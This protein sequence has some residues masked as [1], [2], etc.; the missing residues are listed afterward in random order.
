[1]GASDFEHADFETTGR[2][3]AMSVCLIFSNGRGSVF[4]A[5]GKE[6]ESDKQKVQR[7]ARVTARVTGDLSA[8]GSG[9]VRLRPR[10]RGGAFRSETEGHRGR[11]CVFS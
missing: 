5:T 2:H 10:T 8:D 7:S 6:T 3:G 11:Q 1:M 4:K 9:R